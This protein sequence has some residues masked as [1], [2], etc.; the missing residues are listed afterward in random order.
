M[1]WGGF[2]GNGGDDRVVIVV[3]VDSNCDGGLGWG[4][5]VGCGGDGAMMVVEAGLVVMVVVMM[6]EV[7]ALG[8][9]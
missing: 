9:G 8:C 2:V 5:F 4:G 1:G 7:A 3:M 6:M